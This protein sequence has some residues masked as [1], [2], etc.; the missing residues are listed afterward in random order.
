MNRYMKLFSFASF[1][2][3]SMAACTNTTTNGDAA[4][5]KNAQAFLDSFSTEYLKVYTKYSEAQWAS[6]T[7]IVEG[8]STNAVAEQKAGKE[9]SDFAGNNS[10]VDKVQSFLKEK[11]NLT[12]LQVK[13]LEAILYQAGNYTQKAADAV[14]ERIKAETDQIAKL[15]GFNYIIDGK[16]VTTN[17]IDSILR[18]ETNVAKRLSAWNTSK[19]VGRNLKTGLAHLRDLRNKVVQSI[20]YH[21]FFTYQVSQYGMTSDEMINLCKQINR[22]LHPL[23]RELHTYARYELAKKYNQ[24]TVPDYLPAH[25]VHNRWSQDWSS[26]VEVK[27]INLDSILN[28]KS[29]EWIVQEGEAFYKSLGYPALP[30]TFWQKSSLYPLP[31]GT[32]YKKNNHASAWHIDLQHDVRS[33]MSVEPNTEW[34]ETVHHELGHIYYYIN[35]TNDSVPPILRRGANR[36][37]HEAMGSMIGMAAMQKPFLQGK[38]LLTA[39]AKSDD[40]Q[41]LLQEALNYIV[42]IPFATGTMTEFERDLYENNLP[43]DQFNKR[44][45]ELAKKYQGIEPPSPRGEEYCDAA[46]K[47]HINDDAAQYY[48][49]A[50]SYVILFQLHDYIAKN[51]LKQDPHATNY[52]GNKDVGEFLGSI[53]RKGATQDWRQVLKDATGQ[54]ISAKAMVDYFAPLTDYLKEVN[55][56]RKYTLEENF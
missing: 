55:K 23:F 22:E 3:L 7:K 14:K 48:D 37:F 35:Y 34:F 5:Q 42:F 51:I 1:I 11:E 30:Q 26:M 43:A 2:A 50:L 12:P 20:G 8:D 56:G 18:V 29:A 24:S 19:E 25:W 9:Y 38:G 4:L 36:A 13:Q 17:N 32:N 46:T 27:G 47:T 39:D 31:P 33:L 49:Y 21:D 41:K 28:K 40:T 10:I 52:F 44:W 54:E 45:W 6:N 16:P 53:M 15:Y